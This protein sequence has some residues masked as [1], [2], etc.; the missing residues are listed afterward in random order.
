MKLNFY[1]LREGTKPTIES[2]DSPMAPSATSTSCGTSYCSVPM[3]TLTMSWSQPLVP[4]AQIF[5]LC[6]PG[7]NGGEEKVYISGSA[8]NCIGMQL[9][10]PQ[11]LKCWLNREQ[12][13][14]PSWSRARCH[15]SGSTALTTPPPEFL[16]PL[17]L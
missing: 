10:W 8:Q 12:P 3:L 6:K 16:L 5:S 11:G 14:P 2:F 7:L 1:L 15:L 4:H 13:S 9:S 17:Q